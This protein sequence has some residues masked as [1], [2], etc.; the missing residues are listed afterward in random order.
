MANSTSRSVSSVVILW[1]ALVLQTTAVDANADFSAWSSGSAASPAPAVFT[2]GDY[3]TYSAAAAPP[4]AA[5]PAAP[6]HVP[7]FKGDWSPGLKIAAKKVLES[8]KALKDASHELRG[9]AKLVKGRLA[10]NAM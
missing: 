9:A 10:P 8:A 1:I 4:A 2:P 7:R 3:A 6:A 5:P